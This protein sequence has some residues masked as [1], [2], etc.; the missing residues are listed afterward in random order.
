MNPTLAAVV[1][2]LEIGSA[3]AKGMI[4][5]KVLEN[6]FDPLDDILLAQMY[7]DFKNLLQGFKNDRFIEDF[8]LELDKNNNTSDDRNNRQANVDFSVIPIDA[9]EKLFINATVRESGAVL[10]S[11]Q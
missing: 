9:L 2:A 3:C 5:D 11:V 1:A 4:T 10:N 6:G 8:S 7:Q